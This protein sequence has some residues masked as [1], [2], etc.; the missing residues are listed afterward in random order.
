[1]NPA[2]VAE[3][4]FTAYLEAKFALDERSLNPE[5]QGE[6][7]R[8]LAHRGS[9]TGLDLGTGSGASVRRLLTL[10]PGSWHLTAVDREPSLLRQAR[11]KSAA[12][13]RGQ[14]F[15][16]APRPD[17]I[18]AKKAGRE[19]SVTFV[20]ADL[21]DLVP[22][23]HAFDF[24]LA[25]AVL[26]LLPLPETIGALAAGLKPG[27][28]F[29]ATLL[30]DGSTTLFPAYRDGRLEE[31]ILAVYDTSMEQRRVRGLR[32]GGSR[33]GRRCLEALESRGF[34]CIAYGS[35]DWNLTPRR[36][37][38]RDQDAVC[39]AALLGMIREEAGRSGHF[40]S[41]AL[42]A[43]YEDRRGRLG[44]GELGLIVH[45]LDVLAEKD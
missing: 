5:T 32:S 3:I 6:F 39:L 26:D 10:L 23:P 20:A 28:L 17:G 41:P 24:V 1:M 2:E 12:L 40:A 16:L 11:E 37:R 4:D 31:E 13:L 29:Y 38:Y 34:A 25:H 8:A 35:S 45:Q 21:L 44:A 14:G 43:W 7:V 33:S 18:A 9:V 22:E 42:A 36:R 27:G 30:Y 19:V 15:R